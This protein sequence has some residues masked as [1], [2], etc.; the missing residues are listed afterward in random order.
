MGMVLLS[1]LLFPLAG[2]NKL[3][4]GLTRMISG[5]FQI[6][7][8]IYFPVWVD[9]FGENRKTLWLSYIQ[10]AVV[11]GV[12]MGYIITALFNILNERYTWISWRWAFYL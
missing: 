7:L 11:L 10:L 1:S 12:V 6:S 5:F 2:R 8:V 3:I 9:T 4:M